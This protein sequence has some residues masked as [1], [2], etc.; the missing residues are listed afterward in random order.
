M[1]GLYTQ[2]PTPVERD[3]TIRDLLAVVFKRKW[4]IVG[5]FLVASAI[6]AF[7]IFNTPV[8]FSADATVMLN[9]K[10]RESVLQNG[11][12]A[13]PWKEVIE[14]EVE[15]VRSVPVLARALAKLNAPTPDHPK[16]LG[17]GLGVLSTNVKAGMIGESN[18]IFVTAKARKP[19]N[20]LRMAN[21]VADAYIE[22]H[23]ELFKLPDPSA[24]IKHQADSTLAALQN[25][26]NQRKTLLSG[27]GLTDINQEQNNLIRVKS[28]VQSSLAGIVVRRS[29][30]E[31]ELAA[32]RRLGS[33]ETVLP[34]YEAM[35]SAQGQSVANA[36]QALRLKSMQL[37]ELR[38]KYTEHHPQV[39]EVELEAA[40]LRAQLASSVRDVIAVKEHELDVAHGEEAALQ[41]QQSGLEE[42]LARLP[43]LV[44]DL[45][46]LDTQIGSASKQYG[47]L[48][49]QAS[50][51]KIKSVSYEDYGVKLLSPAVDAQKN[52]KGDL[53][54]IA[55]GPLL[56]L[57]AGI[58]LAFYLENLDHS[59]ET[60]EDVERH[61]EIP[62]LASFPDVDVT[63]SNL[64]QKAKRL[65]FSRGKAG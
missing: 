16:G 39:Q 2:G 19:E 58:G 25:L 56:A 1:S 35:G 22:Y 52:K 34:F 8:T 28:E 10:G 24:F 4:L 60:R 53:V 41:K 45:E 43:G 32:A 46:M 29:R 42:R 50:D 14:S 61:L 7:K 33:D 38:S 36:V 3:T 15:V 54:R 47:S 51:S 65:P 55:L 18:I 27:I 26:Q 37:E 40:Q 59:L 44:R 13:L 21:A 57:M 11:G 30:L 5:I 6:T 31:T 48:N 12:S 64:D 49:E 63:D 20:A 9:R 23:L 62:V 17:Y